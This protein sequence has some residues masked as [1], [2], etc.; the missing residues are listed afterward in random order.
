V[1]EAAARVLEQKFALGLFENPYVDVKQAARI[2]GSR[3]FVHEGR[4]AQVR[5][6][7]LLKNDRGLLPVRP[8]RHRTFLYGISP[9][10]ARRHGFRVVNDLAQADLALIRIRA[11]Y[12]QLH[13]NFFFGRRQHEGRLAYQEGDADFDALRAASAR[14]PTI[15][16]V[17]LDRPAILTNVQPLARALIA[18]FG[19]RDDALL[20]ALT[21]RHP[22]CARLPIELPSS[23]Q[24][25]A[26][27]QPDV[28][29]DSPNPLYPIHFGGC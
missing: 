6:L 1:E 8:Q 15:V 9:E 21:H 7:V 25:V 24:A 18:N 27:Q 10:V 2:V 17:Y 14:V 28:P 19:I 22:M 11:P 4:G 3:A 16:T 29:H 23:L 26:A 12:E 13:P 5:S 20:E